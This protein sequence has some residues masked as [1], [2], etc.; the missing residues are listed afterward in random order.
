MRTSTNTKHFGD[1]YYDPDLQILARTGGEQ[2]KLRPKSLNVFLHLAENSNRVVSKE[3]IMSTVW[4]NIFVTD[5][6]LTQCIADIRR[7]LDDT[8]HTLLKTIPRKG[9]LFSPNQPQFHPVD[10][11]PFYGRKNELAELEHMLEKP[12]CR[13]LVILG[14]GGVGKS[15][16]SQTLKQRLQSQN[17]YE[18]GVVLIPL[19]SLHC[20]TLIP[21]AIAALTGVSLQGSRS[22]EELLIEELHTHE[23][24]LI[25][26]N[27]EH[28]LPDVEICQTLLNSCPGLNIL[29]TSRLP[30]QLE[31]E[32]V[33]HL[34]GF[35]LPDRA[36]QLAQSEAGQLFIDTAS[37]INHNFHSDGQNSPYIL[38]ICKLLGGMPLGIEIAARWVQHLSC[39]EIVYEMRQYLSSIEEH[40]IETDHEAGALVKVLKQSWDMLTERERV[41][42]QTLALFRGAFTRESA[43]ATAGVEL[44]DYAGLINKSM[45]TRDAEGGYVLHAVMR[46]YATKRR[47][48]APEH[49]ATVSQKFFDFHLE[50]ARQADTGILGGKQLHNIQ[51]LESEH[52]NFRECLALCHPRYSAKPLDINGGL[53]LVGELG[54]FWFLA[55]HWKEGREWAVSFL[56]NCVHLSSSNMHAKALLTA[57]GLSVLLDDYT[58]A[59]KYLNKG[60][61]IAADKGFSIQQAR[62]L[63]ASGVLRRLQGRLPEAISC[64]RNSMELF[65]SAGD[66]G[67]YQFNLGNL[68]HSLLMSGLHDEAEA[69][70]EQC[71]C[72]NQRIGATMSMP[73]ALVNLGRLH[74]KLKQ[75]ETAKIYLQQA[76][77]VSDKLGILLYRAQ[78]LCALGWIQV[79]NDNQDDSLDFFQR[80]AKDYL[81]LGDR[82]GLA[83]TMKGVAVSKA[84]KG[85]LIPALQFMTVAEVL[86]EDWEV[87]VLT[88][89]QVLLD[90]AMV[91]IQKGLKPKE[92]ALYRNLG[93]AASPEELFR[94]F[95]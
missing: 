51:C 82:E 60:I 57:G 94:A 18:D 29:L 49:R 24:L 52:S 84:Q 65:E 37:R 38:E 30:T 81:R 36:D 71:I 86:L 66:E 83:D 35:K 1:L 42:V 44:A 13:L 22:K 90:D 33:Y 79:Y 8:R 25:L 26:D 62:G 75:I 32:W 59:D 19:A 54:M 50:T 56:N 41:I 64:G 15:R 10:S 92:R 45:I 55:N 76:I 77:E 5:D 74:W 34:D 95:L 67:G 17:R 6:S 69:T 58:V 31:G 27:I 14:F 63:A 61:A 80:S 68:G 40:H 12:E 93:L 20:S 72:L 9:Y 11:V 16:L 21:S 43:A 23:M 85:E 2:L 87:P 47:L 78:A 73:Y 28:L 39:E 46:R 89:H 70:L 4:E 48:L 7:V 53:E 3:E 88:E 91:R